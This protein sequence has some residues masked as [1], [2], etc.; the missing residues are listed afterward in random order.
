VG[1]NEKDA[2]SQTR[3]KNVD[4]EKRINLGFSGAS[5]LLFLDRENVTF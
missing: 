2:P 3:R 4:R 5:S 1:E